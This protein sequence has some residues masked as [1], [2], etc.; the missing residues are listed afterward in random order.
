MNKLLRLAW[1]NVWRNKRRSLITITAIALS[2]LIIAVT[3]SLQYGTY[4]TMEY[5]AVRLFNGELQVHRKGFQEEQT[6]TYHLRQNELDL[7]SVLEQHPELTAFSRRIT[8]FGLVSSDSASAGALIVGIEPAQE[9]AITQFAGMVQAGKKL[10]DGDDHLVLLGTMLARNLQAG[11]RDTVVVLTQGYRNQLGADTYVVKGL[12]SAGH[13]ELDRSLMVMPLHNAQELFSLD[14]GITQVVFKSSNFR[15]A[16]RLSK[17]LTQSF[18]DGAFEVLSWEELMPGLKQIIIIDNVSGAIYLAF[19]LIVVGIE[20]FNATMLSVVERTREFG[21]LQAVGMKPTQISGLILL[22][23]MIKISISIAAGFLLS[24]VVVSTLSQ[25][26]IPLPKDIVEGYASYGFVFD[27][28]KFSGK[29]RVYFE[30]VVSI[31]IIGV[32]A[33]LFPV[34]KTSRLSPV[35]AFRKT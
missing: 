30:P 6:L 32:L 28:L 13:S 24:L 22:E 3:R 8:S 7:Q 19:I 33:V 26:A 21:I 11:V 10:Q 5:M 14:D 35:E 16:P 9:G 12:L 18:D 29:A 4:D 15:N 34:Y 17:V 31:A 25:F 27:D 20:I 1:R 2:I 23:S